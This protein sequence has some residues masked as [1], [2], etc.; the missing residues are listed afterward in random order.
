MFI[1]DAAATMIGVWYQAGHQLKGVAVVGALSVGEAQRSSL[2][3]ALLLESE[4]FLDGPFSALD[5]SMR[6]R[7]VLELLELLLGPQI[8]T[9]FVSH[10]P[11]AG[12]RAV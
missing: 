5:Q 10:D 1:K 9:M 11:V 6:R 2:V 4:L 7:L 3:G 12:P 8:A